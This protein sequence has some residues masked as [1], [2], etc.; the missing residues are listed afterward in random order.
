MDFFLFITTSRP[1]S[2][3]YN[4][5]LILAN[6]SDKRLE[7]TRFKHNLWLSTRQCA[8]A[9]NGLLSVIIT[10]LCLSC[11]RWEV[12]R[13]PAVWRK[14]PWS[15][16]SSSSSR[17]EV[18]RGA[19]AETF[20]LSACSAWFSSLLSVLPARELGVKWSITPASSTL[21]RDLCLKNA[22]RSPSFLNLRDSVYYLY[23]Y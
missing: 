16:S 8:H 17:S 4:F 3:C 13:S 18:F 11:T 14:D 6:E 5:P 9:N 21:W 10:A 23:R 12:N 22:H 15:S 2:I 19:S 20:L 7:E 1:L